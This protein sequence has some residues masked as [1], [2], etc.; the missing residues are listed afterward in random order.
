MTVHVMSQHRNGTDTGWCEQ[1]LKLMAPLKGRMADQAPRFFSCL[2]PNIAQAHGAAVLVQA[3]DYCIIRF[4]SETVTRLK[5]A[6]LRCLTSLFDPNWPDNSD[7]DVRLFLEPNVAAFVG[8]GEGLV[9]ILLVIAKMCKHHSI[10]DECIKILHH[11]SKYKGQELFAYD[12]EGWSEIDD[13]RP[14]HDL[15]ESLYERILNT[16]LRSSDVLAFGRCSV[17]AAKCVCISFETGSTRRSNDTH[18]LGS[19]RAAWERAF[20]MAGIARHLGDPD[21]P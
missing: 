15:P 18:E 16:Y 5:P 7:T 4:S 6:W 17:V 19:Y 21:Q 3:P 8:H 9:P 11:L 13:A 20:T 2:P 1:M 14:L 12:D 10:M